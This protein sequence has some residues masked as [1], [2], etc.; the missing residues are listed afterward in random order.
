MPNSAAPTQ[1]NKPLIPLWSLCPWCRQGDLGSDNDAKR[2]CLDLD[3]LPESRLQ[4]TDKTYDCSDS[5]GRSLGGRQRP[6]YLED[7]VLIDQERLL[8]RRIGPLPNPAYAIYI[9]ALLE[10]R[11]LWTGLDDLSAKVGADDG[12]PIMDEYAILLHYGITI[13]LLQASETVSCD[14]IYV[15]GRASKEH[16]LHWVE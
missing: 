3:Q 8:K 15:A 12:R 14:R 1:D 7:Q 16:R 11:A 6:L 10:L 4:V 2:R 9:I 5:N 13:C